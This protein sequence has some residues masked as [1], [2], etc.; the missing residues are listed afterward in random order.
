MTQ[1]LNPFTAQTRVARIRKIRAVPP[2]REG[3][4]ANGFPD[5]FGT[6][7]CALDLNPEKNANFSVM[8]V[9]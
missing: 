8:I 3:I 7:A 9:N 5:D 2:S 1:S 6:N 4:I